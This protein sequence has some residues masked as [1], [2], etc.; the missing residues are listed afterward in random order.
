MNESNIRRFLKPSINW[1]AIF[2]PIAFL[3][4]YVPALHNKLWLFVTACLAMVVCSAWIA[5]S[6]DSLA[7]VVGPTWGGMMNAAFGNLPEL[8]F[9]L[10]AV[11]KGLG[12]LA[13]AAWVGSVIGNV[14]TVIGGA[15]LV[16]GLKYGTVKFPAKPAIDSCNNLILAVLGMFLPSIYIGAL[17]LTNKSESSA[18]YTEQISLSVAA[19]LLLMYVASLIFTF[20]R[21]RSEA[22]RHPV[23]KQAGEAAPKLSPGTLAAMGVLALSSVLI[24]FLSDFVTD[25]VDTVKSTFGLTDLFIGIVVIGTI[26]N[27]SAIWSAI[28]AALK[29]KMELAY[30]IGMSA[31]TQII[32]L[33]VPVL[34]FASRLFGHPVDLHFSNAELAALF[35]GAVLVSRTSNVGETD[36]LS[37]LQLLIMFALIGA[38]FFFLPG[39]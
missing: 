7:D 3:M 5:N 26:G 6:T 15:M 31:G 35:G 10:I 33:V 22:A 17:I 24:S 13:K 25:S 27:V 11:S 34:V 21:S 4:G 12:D 2:I 30:E 29:N 38:L 20:T 16:A 9:G 18:N 39:A 32:L 1:L 19:L 23:A 28:Q 14:L 36:W 37:G 8:I